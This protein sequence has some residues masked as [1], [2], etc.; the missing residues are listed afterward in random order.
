MSHLHSLRIVIGAATLGCALQAH[1]QSNV[2]IFGHLNLGVVKETGGQTARVDR[3][4]LN[5]L[6]F[7]GV[8]DLGGGLSATFNLT[9]RFMADT[10]TTESSVFWHGES[11]VGLASKSLGSIRL[12]RALTPLF[13]FKYEFEPWA[14]SWFM[15]SLGKYQTGD[16]FFSNPAA[17]VSDCPGFG[18]LNNGVFYDSPDMGGLRL[19]VASQAEVEP[20]ANRRNLSAALTFHQGAFS[21]MVSGERNA[22]QGSAVYAAA[23]YAFARAAIMGSVSRNTLSGTPSETNAIV[24]GTYQVDGPHS[25]R[26][27]LGRN[28]HKDHH[29]ESLGYVYTLSKRSSLYADLYR[30]KAFSSYTGYAAGIAHSF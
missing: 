6:G 23:K 4:Y 14:D 19:S 17:C 16:R 24:A 21:A 9:T 5:W 15:G 18:R 8:E 3:G 27:G 10:G 11:T 29:K 20:G 26:F 7:S 12:G 2:T 30:E 28:F 25:L 22:T 1:A 13:A